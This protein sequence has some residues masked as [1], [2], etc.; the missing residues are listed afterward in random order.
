MTARIPQ[1]PLWES[2]SKSKKFQRTKQ[3]E[4]V[5]KAPGFGVAPRFKPDRELES[6]EG[7]THIPVWSS[8]QKPKSMGGTFGPRQVLPH[9]PSDT[10]NVDPKARNSEGR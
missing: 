5:A 3:G 1:R 2:K 6:D 7:E 10:K 9:E 8:F 4:A